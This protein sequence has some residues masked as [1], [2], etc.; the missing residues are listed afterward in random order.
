[1]TGKAD[2]TDEEWEV[3]LGAPPLAGL[4]VLTAAHGGT[5]RESLAVGKAYGEARQQHGASQLLDEVVGSK[6]KVDHTRFG[7]VD[8]LNQHALARLRE[9]VEP[10]ERKATPDEVE[11]YRA[12][13]TTLAEKVANAHREEGVAVS[14]SERAAMDEIASALGSGGT[15]TG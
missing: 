11:D 12:F 3:I 5:F 6:P 4:M 14:E 13:V 10:L 9:A 15:P 7:S 2:F 1:M 8:E